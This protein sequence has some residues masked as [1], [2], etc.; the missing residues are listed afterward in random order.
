MNHSFV[1]VIKHMDTISLVFSCSMA[2]S[3]SSASFGQ[4]E[5]TCLV[6]FSPLLSQVF[7]RLFGFI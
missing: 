5:Q 2:V 4:L 7:A 1:Q 6:L 3:L